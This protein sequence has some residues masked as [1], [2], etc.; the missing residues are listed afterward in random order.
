MKTVALIF[1]LLVFPVFATQ[2]ATDNFNRADANSLGA[3]WTL[4]PN[5][6]NL[7]IVSNAVEAND[8]PGLMAYN[9]RTADQDGEVGLTLVTLAVSSGQGM[10]PARRVSIAANTGYFVLGQAARLELYKVTSDSY[11]L[12]AT[13]T[14]TILTTDII[15]LRATGTSTTVLKV[16]EN[17]VERIS[18]SDN[19]SPITSG[20]DGMFGS[21]DGAVHPTGDNW[22]IDDL[23][24]GGGSTAAGRSLLLGVGK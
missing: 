10:G 21:I 12:L 8:D 2:V 5:N 11:S 4:S 23:A 16:Y 14:G 7:R 18:Y 1:L 22:Y 6:H 15:S 13:Y 9:A 24:G 20:S 19:S 17:S 3:N